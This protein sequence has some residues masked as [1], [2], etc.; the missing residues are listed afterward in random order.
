[1]SKCKRF[2]SLLILSLFVLS[3]AACENGET[4]TEPSASPD[5]GASQSQQATEP[6]PT[7]P[8][9]AE[10][11]AA[12]NAA[13]EKLLSAE[14]Y[15]M[16]GSVNSIASVE[17]DG[18]SVVSMVD[19][20]HSKE[21]GTLFEVQQNSEFVN[22]S[23]STYFDGQRYYYDTEDLRFGS[24]SNDYLDFDASGYL[25]PVQEQDLFLLFRDEEADCTTLRFSVP[26]Q[27]YNAPALIEL[28]G[29]IYSDDALTAPVDLLVEIDTEGNLTYL[30]MYYETTVSFGDAPIDQSIIAAFTFTE[31]GTT[32]IEIPADLDS[33]G[34]LSDI[35][36]GG[37][38]EGGSQNEG[39]GQNENGEDVDYEDYIVD[40]S[41]T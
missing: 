8:T 33:Y 30:Y 17:G 35:M 34:E 6:A 7:P 4:P 11:A 28:L 2:L 39:G 22:Y 26:F 38:T 25:L 5:G 23:H 27:T 10:I 13:V 31:Q 15:T 1:M 16:S 3:F 21:K 40:G 29:D 18:S 41:L 20:R 12:Y 32:Q 9:A 24:S 36:E 14:S 37:E 19:C